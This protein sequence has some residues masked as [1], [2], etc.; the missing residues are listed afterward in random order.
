M[1]PAWGCVF[2]KKTEVSL[3]HTSPDK[4]IVLREFQDW[5]T[6]LLPTES[7]EDLDAQTPTAG[8]ALR[9]GLRGHAP[10]SA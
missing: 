5:A 9:L 8:Q 2:P 1:R 7:L 3:A 6:A 4:F 10:T